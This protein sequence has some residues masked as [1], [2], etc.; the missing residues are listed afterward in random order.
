[1]PT[2]HFDL[3][4]DTAITVESENLTYKQILLERVILKTWQWLQNRYRFSIFALKEPVTKISVS[5]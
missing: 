4:K 3:S 2:P 5:R 1:M